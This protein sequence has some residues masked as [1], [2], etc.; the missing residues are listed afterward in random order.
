MPN[1]IPVAT[2]NPNE[3]K[4]YNFK[5]SNRQQEGYVQLQ[6]LNFNINLVLNR[7][8]ALRNSQIYNR[9]FYRAI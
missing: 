6:R 3:H 1:D 5:T 8:H 2:F 7:S 9:N 4:N